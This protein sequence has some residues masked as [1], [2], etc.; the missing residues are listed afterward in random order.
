MINIYTSLD[1][2]W[3]LASFINNF[4]FGG[5]SIQPTVSPNELR[6]LGF[7]ETV[8]LPRCGVI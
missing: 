6:G 2:C 8:V 5:T 3:I 7:K 1:L 4:S